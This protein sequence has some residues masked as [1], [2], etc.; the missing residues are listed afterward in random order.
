MS[1]SDCAQ[2]RSRSAGDLVIS[3]IEVNRHEL[4]I[5]GWLEQ[6]LQAR[7]IDRGAPP[8]DFIRHG[9]LLAWIECSFVHW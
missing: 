4:P 8:S 6:T 9:V 1:L 5:E 3:R 7:F 2:G